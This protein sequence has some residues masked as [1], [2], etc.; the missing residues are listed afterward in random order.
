MLKGEFGPDIVGK[1]TSEIIS[2]ATTESFI[3]KV[4]FLFSF[5]PE[6]DGRTTPARNSI[7]LLVFING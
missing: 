3:V 2:K 5:F 4:Q 7:G 1:D 6:F